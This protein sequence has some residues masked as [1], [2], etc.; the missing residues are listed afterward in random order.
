[1]STPIACWGE[2]VEQRGRRAGYVV[3]A[4]K[5]FEATMTAAWSELGEWRG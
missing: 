1:M 3:A 5:P 2:L 4:G